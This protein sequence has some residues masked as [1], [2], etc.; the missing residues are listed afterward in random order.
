MSQLHRPSLIEA[1]PDCTR[2]PS[3]AVLSLYLYMYIFGLIHGT[4][5]F[6]M[7]VYLLS[8][9]PTFSLN[10]KCLELSRCSVVFLGQR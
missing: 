2:A 5:H 6:V 3:S 1:L 7:V 10:I 4:L 8:T 9:S